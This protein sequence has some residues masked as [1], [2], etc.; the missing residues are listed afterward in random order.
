[1]Q[2]TQA[3][4]HERSNV[5]QVHIAW[6]ETAEID[7]GYEVMQKVAAGIGVPLGPILDRASELSGKRRAGRC[8]ANSIRR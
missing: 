4:L 3:E 7:P 1:M 6:I 5:H 8:R 2:L